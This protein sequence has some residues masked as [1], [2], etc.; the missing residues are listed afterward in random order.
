MA[1]HRNALTLS[2]IFANLTLNKSFSHSNPLYQFNAIMAE[3]QPYLQTFL[4][5]LIV[6]LHLFFLSSHLC[7]SKVEL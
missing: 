3:H 2:K 4:G 1:G 6:P 5:T 7:F